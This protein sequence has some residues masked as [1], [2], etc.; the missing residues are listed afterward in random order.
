MNLVK[1][2][3]TITPFLASLDASA[4]RN[5]LLVA[6]FFNKHLGLRSKLNVGLGQDELHMA[7]DVLIQSSIPKLSCPYST[8]VLCYVFKDPS[9]YT[10]VLFF[11]NQQL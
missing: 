4:L 7:F 11:N 2:A 8:I 6:H 1:A 3:P 9:P 10:Q 5:P